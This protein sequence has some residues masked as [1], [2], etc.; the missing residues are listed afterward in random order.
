MFYRLRLINLNGTYRHTNIVEVNTTCTNSISNLNVYPNPI[1]ITENNLNV[2]YQNKTEDD[3]AWV[4]IANLNGTEMM[5]FPVK[6]VL[7]KNELRIDISNLLVGSYIFYIKKSKGK[8]R[9][10]QFVI[11]N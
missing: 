8:A 5:S 2:S 10:Q 3:V 9:T 4:I 1:G 11:V 7:G 6:S